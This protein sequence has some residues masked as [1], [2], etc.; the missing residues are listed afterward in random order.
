MAIGELAAV[1]PKLL[2]FAWQAVTADGVDAGAR[3]DVEWHAVR[4]LCES[5]GDVAEPQAGSWL[6][7][8]PDCSAPLRLEGGRE[9]DLLSLSFE[10]LS[11]RRA[12]QGSEQSSGQ[13]SERREVHA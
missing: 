6:R 1:E 5:C 3:L 7:L 11:E 2:E 10:P 13:G 9:L 4:Q 8:C 12:E